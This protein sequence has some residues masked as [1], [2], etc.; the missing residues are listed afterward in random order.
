M[1]SASLP[2]VRQLFHGVC[3]RSVA[4]ITTMMTIVFELIHVSYKKQQ[5]YSAQVDCGL[6]TLVAFAG[7]QQNSPALF[8]ILDFL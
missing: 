7:L 8:E 2:P 3:T 1:F 5:L 4:F 6:T